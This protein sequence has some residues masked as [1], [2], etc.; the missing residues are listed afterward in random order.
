MVWGIIRGRWRRMLNRNNNCLC[1]S[2]NRFQHWHKNYPTSLSSNPHLNKILH[3]LPTINPN[4]SSI[5]NNKSSSYN[6][7]S[8]NISSNSKIR[9]TKYKKWLNWSTPKRQIFRSWRIRSS[10]WMRN[11]YKQQLTTSNSSSHR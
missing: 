11:C 1:W 8:P 5:S 7:N 4:K 3:H 10:H 6:P 9:M 2:S